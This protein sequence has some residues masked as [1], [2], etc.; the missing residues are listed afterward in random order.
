MVLAFIVAIGLLVT[1][2]E[3]GHY[4]VARKM[5]VK[6]LRFSIGF[7]KPLYTWRL[8]PDNTE[9]VIAMIP[10]GGYVKMAD[11]REAEVATEDLPRAFNRQSVYK[12]FAIVFAGPLFNFIFAVV[13]YWLMFVIGVNGITP[14]IG[15]VIEGSPAMLAGI[16]PATKIIRV[17]GRDTP[18]WE[19]VLFAILDEVVGDGVINITVMDDNQQTTDHQI[20]LSN[21]NEVL[22]KRNILKSI[23]FRPF[24]PP[25]PAIIGKLTTGERAEAAG[26][27]PGDSLLSADGT[28]IDDWSQ[29]V[30]FVRQRPEQEIRLQIQR[31]QQKIT[32]RITPKSIKDSKNNSIGFIGAANQRPAGRPKGYFAVLQYSPFKAIGQALDK[33]WRVSLLTVRVLGKM[34]V[35]DA[36]VKNISGPISIAQYAGYSA[37]IGMGQYLAFLAIVSISL[38]ILNLLPVPLL[39]GGHLMYYA[40]EMVKGSPVSE[41]VQMFGQRIGIALLGALMILAIYNDIV[42]LL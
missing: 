12:R 33:T 34:L 31:Q 37:A 40:V 1:V 23:G 24:R 35:G 10:L 2:H 7:G 14:R 42:R 9:Y 11:E 25:I 41:A 27:R 13:A 22:N 38:G 8:G 3:F 18:T 16:Q 39:D 15:E 29:W 19:T 30:E 20:R 32:L 6:V 21:P 4:W 5:G 36:S 28:N 17:Q 26:L